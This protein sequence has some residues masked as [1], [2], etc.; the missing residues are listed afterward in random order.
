[1]VC[2]YE[3]LFAARLT[4]LGGRTALA[5]QVVLGAHT[6]PGTAPSREPHHG[7]TVPP[8]K[9][10]TMHTS[11]NIITG[12]TSEPLSIMDRDTVEVCRLVLGMRKTCIWPRN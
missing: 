1:V 6:S 9:K 10:V 11:D 8:R 4:H 2:G 7:P 5:N 12:N 3:D